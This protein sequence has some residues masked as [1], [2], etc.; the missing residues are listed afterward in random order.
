MGI[1]IKT[2]LGT[3]NRKLDNGLLVGM[4]SNNL[5]NYNIDKSEFIFFEEEHIKASY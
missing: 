2:F 4:V 3:T 1:Y 5:T